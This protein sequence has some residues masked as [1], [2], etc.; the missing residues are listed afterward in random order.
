MAV[1]CA[2]AVV[3]VR[4]QPCAGLLGTWVASRGDDHST[5]AMLTAALL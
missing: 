2:C 1:V 5:G 3:R 4:P